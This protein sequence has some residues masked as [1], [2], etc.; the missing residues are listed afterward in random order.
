MNEKI[1]LIFLLFDEK[2]PHCSLPKKTD[3][4]P[5]SKMIWSF[6]GEKPASVSLHR[7]L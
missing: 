4:Q 6:R 1:G 2:L 3:N 5:E 7:L